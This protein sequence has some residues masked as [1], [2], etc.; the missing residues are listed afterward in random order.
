MTWTT[1]TSYYD[2]FTVGAGYLDIWAALN[3]SAVVPA[4]Y[5][6]LSPTAA[7]DPLGNVSILIDNSV[8][9]G[10]AR[11]VVWG[12]GVLAG[13]SVIA[14]TSLVWGTGT[15][16]GYSLVWGNSLVWGTT[17]QTSAEGSAI[18]IYGEQ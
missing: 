17:S 1:Y 18:A 5:S 9:W 14:P 13:T 6:A 12:T 7:I 4:G 16:S 10:T 3:S 15:L 2:L 8:V 11:S